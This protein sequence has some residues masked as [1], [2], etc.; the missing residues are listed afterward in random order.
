MTTEIDSRLRDF[1]LQGFHQIIAISEDNINASLR[2]R[3]D[4]EVQPELLTFP[5]EIPGFGTAIATLDPPTVSVCTESDVETTVSRFFLNFKHGAYQ[6]RT[7]VEGGD[8]ERV[9]L[10]GWKVAFDVRFDEKKL[11]APPAGNPALESKWKSLEPGKYSLNQIVIFLGSAPLSSLDWER[12]NLPDLKKDDPMFPMKE[13]FFK[14]YMGKY[15]AELQKRPELLTLGYAIK[16]E[17]PDEDALNPTYPPTSVKY[18]NY[19]YQRC[20]DTSDTIDGQPV[21]P[22]ARNAFLFLEMTGGD[23]F[24]REKLD[25]KGNIIVGNMPGGLVLGRQLFMEKYLV[26]SAFPDYHS[27]MIDTANTLFD[28]LRDKWMTTER[29]DW[30]LTDKSR[31][32]TVNNLSWTMAADGK[33]ASVDW[34]D[35]MRESTNSFWYGRYGQELESTYKATLSPVSRTNEITV[36]TGITLKYHNWNQPPGASTTDHYIEA[37]ISLKL[38]FRLVEVKDNGLLHVEVKEDIETCRCRDSEDKSTPGWLEWALGP[39][40]TKLAD[41]LS[42]ELRNVVTTR[43]IGDVLGTRINNQQQFV[44]PGSKQFFYKD[45]VFSDACDLLVRLEYQQK[46]LA[47]E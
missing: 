38:S 40:N 21:T 17:A 13:M 20:T 43:H 5:H 1:D 9:P 33:S 26:G 29:K 23:G 42:E 11:A 32:E 25:R 8:M 31:D 4:N 15:L 14:M 24:P 2:D 34:K 39:S 12:S 46:D 10:D 16:R 3:F 36:T 35:K 6:Y 47:K 45:P 30:W 19:R 37:E 22:E 41:K 27:N 18:Q 28:W 7:Q 44:L